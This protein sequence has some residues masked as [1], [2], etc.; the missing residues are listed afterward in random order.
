M[1]DQQVGLCQMKKFLQAKKTINKVEKEYGEWESI[2]KP[3]I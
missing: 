3:Y 1:K 2:C